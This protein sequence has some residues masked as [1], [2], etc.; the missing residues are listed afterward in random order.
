MNALRKGAWPARQDWSL[1]E[2]TKALESPAKYRNETKDE[3]ARQLR[4]QAAAIMRLEAELDSAYAEIDKLVKGSRNETMD[5][6]G[7]AVFRRF[8]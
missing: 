3:A 1:V 4:E 2:L 8:N 5:I 7:A 6:R